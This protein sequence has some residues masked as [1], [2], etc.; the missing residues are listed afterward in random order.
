MRNNIKKLA[1]LL[2]LFAM[3][4]LAS[5]STDS[6]YSGS[7]DIT[8]YDAS[9]KKVGSKTITISEEGSISGKAVMNIDNTIYLTEIAGSVSSSNGKV[10]DGKLTD[11][12]KLEMEGVLTGSFNKTEGKGEWKNYYSKSGTWKANRSTK[13]DKR[14]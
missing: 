13:G 11:T 9:G 4:F 12:D 10:L 6:D 5:G 2:S 1:L 14:G 7:W 8:F 3:F